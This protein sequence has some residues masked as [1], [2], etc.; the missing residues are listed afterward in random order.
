MRP[1][2]RDDLLDQASADAQEADDRNRFVVDLEGYEGPL[3]L[4]LDL[5]RRQK[6]DLRR[7]SVLELADQYLAF[8]RDVQDRRMDL[9]ADY[10][11]MAAWLAYLKSRLL[12]PAKVEEEAEGGGGGEGM[13]Q[14]LA[15]RLARLAAMRE[16]S[17]E[18]FRGRLDGRDVFARG[19]PQ[20]PNIVRTSVWT[21]SFYDLMKAFGDI[22]G[23]R[24]TRRAHR[25][26]RQPV[27]PLEAAR[28]R[29]AA[30][31]PELDEWTTVDAV[32]TRVG[33]APEAPVRSV[34]ASVFSA[35]LE[36][37]R[38]RAL[39]LR[40]DAPYRDLYLRRIRSGRAGSEDRE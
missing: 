5:A 30:L 8:V 40:Q 6:V 24:V 32:R 1:P 21:T 22:N 27:L 39:E 11:L 16:A 7:I 37:T 19:D 34:V 12:L 33:A 25:V 10:L 23:R 9:A 36:L 20:I 18:L 15:F 38:E 31:L 29:L 28:R 17:S 26:R 13:A 2:V 3:H 4:L 35:A 14:R